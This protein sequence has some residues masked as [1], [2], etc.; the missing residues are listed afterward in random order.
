MQFP[1]RPVEMADCELSLKGY[2]QTVAYFDSTS[3]LSIVILIDPHT[4]HLLPSHEDI[5]KIIS[6]HYYLRLV[7]TVQT[8]HS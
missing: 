3:P 7:H 1:L 2:E 8:F 4:L 6:I 5:D